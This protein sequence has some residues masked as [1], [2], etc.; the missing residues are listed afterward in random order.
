MCSCFQKYKIEKFIF[1]GRKALLPN[2]PKNNRCGSVFQAFWN[3]RIPSIHFFA[4]L[5][6]N[7]VV[8]AEIRVEI[9]C[10]TTKQHWLLIIWK[11]VKATAGPRSNRADRFCWVI[12]WQGK[13]FPGNSKWQKISLDNF[14]QFLRLLILRTLFIG[15]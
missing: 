10:K 7:L 4:P 2:L 13:I 1:N 5:F 8:T 11:C 15:V 12:W 3:I 9:E 6:L 14:P